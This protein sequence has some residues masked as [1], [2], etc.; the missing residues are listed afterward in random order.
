[1]SEQYVITELSID[2]V[3]LKMSDPHPER[4]PIG[5]FASREEAWEYAT[6]M[7][8]AYG[9]G[10]GSVE[11]APLHRPLTRPEAGA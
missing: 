5:P 1:M 6:W 2:G 10:G 4:T 11:V 8:A 9:S 3:V 7:Q